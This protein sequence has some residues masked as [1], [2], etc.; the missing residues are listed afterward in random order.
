[1]TPVATMTI[2]LD[3]NGKVNL[4]G[5]LNN[6]LLCYGM[7]G[8]AQQILTEQAMKQSGANLMVVPPMNGLVKQA[9]K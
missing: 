8:V 7:L 4:E 5:P 6:R 9:R 3:E 1:M 2:T